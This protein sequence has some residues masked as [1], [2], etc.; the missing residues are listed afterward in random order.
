MIVQPGHFLPYLLYV[1]CIY[2]NLDSPYWILEDIWPNH[3]ERTAWVSIAFIGVRTIL[4]IPGFLETV[5]S[6][7]AAGMANFWGLISIPHLVFIIGYKVKNPKEIFAYYEQLT[8]MWNILERG[9]NQAQF[10]AI[11]TLYMICIQVLFIGIQGFGTL[12][13]LIYA[14]FC[15]LCVVHCIAM[16][17]MLYL[18]SQIGESIVALPEVILQ[19]MKSRH[20]RAK[21]FNT[22][23]HVK[24]VKS[25]KPIKLCYGDGERFGRNFSRNCFSNLLETAISIVLTYNLN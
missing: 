14:F 15:G 21:S 19:Q 11:S 9:I 12:E 8:I 20:C 18:L 5:R 25:L 13:P 16:F 22:L 7:F 10:I 3:S 24:R 4:L 6:T 1:V 2:W 17:M 23:V